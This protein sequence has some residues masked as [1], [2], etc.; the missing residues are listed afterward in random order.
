MNES[1][2]T[3]KI[4]RKL[5]AAGV[6]CLKIQTLMNNGVPDCWYSG[7][8]GDLWVEYKYRKDLPKKDSTTFLPGLSGLQ[9]HWLNNRYHED[10]EVAVI[11]G[12]PSGHIILTDLEWNDKT[13][14]SKG[15]PETD[16]SVVEWIKS[17][18]L[19]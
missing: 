1:Q 19:V 2:F 17:K 3:Q 11:L 13:I 15:L 12:S 7:P 5:K 10:R 6:Y 14:T 8:K 16:A 18:T 4:N 9:E